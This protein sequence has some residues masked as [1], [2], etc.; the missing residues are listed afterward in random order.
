MMKLRF[1]DILC[2]IVNFLNF[3]SLGK[4]LVI[5]KNNCLKFNL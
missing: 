4:N 1:V 3:I 2:D 5:R